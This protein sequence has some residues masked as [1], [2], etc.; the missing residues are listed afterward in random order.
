MPCAVHVHH[1]GD[2]IMGAIASQITSL[3]IV[4]STIYSD[5]DERN[6]QNSA[7][8]AFVRGIHRGPVNSPHKWPV[9]RKMFPFDDVI[10]LGV[11]ANVCKGDMWVINSWRILLMNDER[12]RMR[13]FFNGTSQCFA[14]L[15]ESGISRALIKLETKRASFFKYHHCNDEWWLFSSDDSHLRWV[16]NH[17]LIYIYSKNM[18]IRSSSSA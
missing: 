5:A 18:H 17:V 14:R 1:Y 3:T 15:Y 13:L 7:S 10:M 8:L 2:A 12:N 16:A 4:Y 6:H 11:I 9:T